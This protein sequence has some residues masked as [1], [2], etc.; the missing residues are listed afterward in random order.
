MLSLVRMCFFASLIAM[1]LHPID[2]P[3][4]RTLAMPKLRVEGRVIDSESGAPVADAAVQLEM[5]ST[6]RQQLMV[7]TKSDAQGMFDFAPVFAGTHHISV[8]AKDYPVAEETYDF[9]EDDE[10]KSVTIAMER[11]PKSMLK[12]VDARGVALVNADVYVFRGMTQL[13][14]GRTAGDGTMPLFIDDGDERTV[15]VV[16]RDGSFGFVRVRSGTP[17]VAVVV[18]EGISTIILNARDDDALDVR[19]EGERIPDAM[20]DVLTLHGTVKRSATRVVFERMPTGVYEFGALRMTVMAGENVGVMYDARRN[21][22][23]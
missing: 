21:G 19:Y 12:A 23:R 13:A 2:T 8:G 20:M 11:K 18:R 22:R 17:K 5:T 1:Q 6:T 7:H 3:E 15:F 16:P 14:F 10:T 9:G 4:S